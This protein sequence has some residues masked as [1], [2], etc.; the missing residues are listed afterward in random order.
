MP[1]SVASLLVQA[2]GIY[3]AAGLVFALPFL[4]KGVKRIDPDAAEGTLG[5]KLMISPG[6]V[7]LWP[8]LLSRW[9]RGVESP[10][11]ECQPH[12]VRRAAGRDA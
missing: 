6:V 12:R 1:V 5:F 9:L 8:L 10:P 4:I 7:A 11:E 2:A 3:V